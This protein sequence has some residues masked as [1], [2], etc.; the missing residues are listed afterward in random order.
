MIK[1]AFT[2]LSKY[3]HKINKNQPEYIN[4]HNFIIKI[5]YLLFS[6]QLKKELAKW[7]SKFYQ[8]K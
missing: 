6:A 1:I 3:V 5:Y 8:Y 2:Q 4:K 7:H